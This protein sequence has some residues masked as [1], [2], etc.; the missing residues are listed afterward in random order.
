MIRLRI[1]RVN[2]PLPTKA[3]NMNYF[4]KSLL[5]LILTGSFQAFAIDENNSHSFEQ[6]RPLNPHREA[7]ILFINPNR[8]AGGLATSAVTYAILRYFMNI[9]NVRATPLNKLATAGIALGT[10]ALLLEWCSYNPSNYG[11]S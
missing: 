7:H 3:T 11:K 9:N 8:L 6:Q 10:S 1:T 2:K 5:V 4:K